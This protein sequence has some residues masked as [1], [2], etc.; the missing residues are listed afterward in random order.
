MQIGIV[1]KPNVGKSTFFC[2]ATLANVEIANYPFTTIKANRGV[3][4]VRGRCPHLDFNTQ[5]VPRN[6]GC[7]NGTRMIPVEL[8]DVAGLVPDAWQGRGLGNQFLDDLRQASALIHVVDASGSTD[9][10]GNAVPPGSHDPVEDVHFLEKEISFWIRGI[11]DKGWEKAARQA[12]MTGQSMIPM[13]HDRLT[14]LG[15]S[16]AQV[17]AAIRD[18]SL[19]ENPMAWGPEDMLRLSDAIRKYSK[20]MIIALNKADLADDAMLKRLTEAAGGMAV[21]T[22]AEAELALKRAAK[23]KLVS[24]LPGEERFTVAEPSKLNANQA[25]ALGKIGEGVERLHGTGVQK[26]LEKAAYELLDLIIVYPV[27]DESRLTDHDGRVLPDAFLVPKGTT[28][29]GLAYKVHTD[30]GESFIR[31]INVRTHRTVGSEYELQNNDV[32]TI[33][34]RK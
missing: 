10:E 27:E 17:V 3:A 22:M 29:R 13:I 25:K 12:H 14:G 15:V 4:F 28:A 23:A 2:G 32:L 34:S 8:L 21:P 1:G 5:C 16:E 31:A 24:Y 26:C 9:L 7:D 33:V 11:L 30:L 20:P 6:A 18:S 19:P